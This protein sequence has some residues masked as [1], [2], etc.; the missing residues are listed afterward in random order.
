MNT[1]FMLLDDLRR[2]AFFRPGFFSPQLRTVLMAEGLDEVS[3][4]RIEALC[5]LL[6][7]DRHQMH[8]LQRRQAARRLR[9]E[10]LRS[11]P[12]KRAAAGLESFVGEVGRLLEQFGIPFATGESSVM[13][14][15][16]RAIAS[17][18]SISGDPRD[19]LR[20]EARRR[21]R[22][23]A[24]AAETIY[25]AFAAALAPSSLSSPK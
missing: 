21:K 4:D 25:G 10:G 14:K 22:N 19:Q 3:V 11:P 8:A 18:T 13:T 24:A 17:D 15:I 9:A 1:K 7:F 20:A 2:E 6:R 5:W 12:G 23:A 16:L